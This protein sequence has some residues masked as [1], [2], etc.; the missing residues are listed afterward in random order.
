MHLF[1]TYFIF[2]VASCILVYFGFHVVWWQTPLF[3]NEILERFQ[4]LIRL[5]NCRKTIP[6]AVQREELGIRDPN[7]CKMFEGV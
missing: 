2:L 6:R 3:W 7:N 4:S 1:F 5:F